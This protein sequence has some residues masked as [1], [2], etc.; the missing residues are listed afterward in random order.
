MKKKESDKKKKNKSEDEE[1]EEIKMEEVMDVY[2]FV[3]HR[4]LA[5]DEGDKELVVELVPDEES[6]LEG[7]YQRSLPLCVCTDVI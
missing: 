2:T 7:K 5:R 6:D 3:A 4:W 1:E